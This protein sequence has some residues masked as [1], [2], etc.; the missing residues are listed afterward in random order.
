MADE[1]GAEGLDQPEHQARD[2]RSPEIAKP[3]QHDDGQRLVADNEAHRGLDEIVEEPD[4][5]AAKRRKRRADR[6]V[7]IAYLD[8]IYAEA[9]RNAG[10]GHGRAPAD[11]DPGAG[12]E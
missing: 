8:R 9:R 3:A 2:Q 1:D 12:G 7:E 4:E 5:R 11:A 10:I 6:E